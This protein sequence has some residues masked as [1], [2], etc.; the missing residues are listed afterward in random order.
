M[1]KVS[2]VGSLFLCLVSALGA[3]AQQASQ[4]FTVEQI[5]SSPFPS[6]LTSSP[7]GQ[8]LAWVFNH[9][10]IRNIWVAEGPD[11]KARRLTHY[12][13][14]NGRDIAIHGFTQDGALLVFS[15]DGKFNPSPEVR[16]GGGSKLFSIGW[17]GEEEKEIAS[18][19]SGVPAPT[20]DRVAYIEKGAVWIVSAKGGEKPEK[21]LELRGSLSQ[22]R[23]SPDGRQL[24]LRSSRGSFPH[25]YS[26]I[27]IL[28]LDS[29]SVSYV[30]PSVYLD[31]SP[32][33]SVDGKKLAFLRRLTGGHRS[34]LTATQFPVP[35]PWEIRV[36]DIAERTGHRLWRSPDDDNFSAA[37]LAWLSER[38]LIFTSEQDGWRRLYSLDLERKQP[39]QLTKGQFEV[40][41]FAVVPQIGKVIASC[42]KDDIDR[43]RLWI[44]SP[45][46]PMQALTTAESIAWSPT[47]AGDGTYVAYLASDARNPAHVRVLPQGGASLRLA[48]EALPSNFPVEQLVV[49]RQVI[50][51]A[52]DGTQIH[53]QLFMPPS[54]FSGR[55]PAV[56]YFH[57]GPVR[58]MLLGWHYSSYYHNAYAFNQYL[59]SRGYVVL[60]VNYRLGIGYGRKFRDVSDGGPRGA[61]EYQD[62]LAGARFLR[63][64]PEVDPARIGLWGGSYGGLMT[65]LGLARNSDLF[66]A[67][68]DLHGVHDWNQWQAWVERD[69]NDHDRTAWKAS[70][71]ADLDTWRSPVLLIHG[72]DDRNVSFSETVWLAHELE[73]RGVNHELLVFPD[74]VH[75]FLLHKNWVKAFEA[76]ADFLDRKLKNGDSI[77]P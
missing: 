47:P 57:G 73:K 10:G 68:V 46:Q 64:M 20:G 71:A 60:S 31:S 72:D 39:E 51:Q 52:T 37:E 12:D 27:A 74:D 35:D 3:G 41:S 69:E 36:Y 9:G 77:V 17:S 55:R 23:W 56:M 14:D 75:A 33:W 5:L 43:R 18:V 4:S 29:K 32:A 49:P 26:F 65:A 59:A 70:P 2:P 38:H 21:V 25:Q 53:G 7:S 15:R 1:K 42:N 13:R 11:F 44:V 62:L 66:A 48:P 63:S 8:R 24:A 19:G 34:V 76:A 61:S 54:H 67:G 16:G 30:D 6:S 58:Q 50:F 28:D 22:L 45:E 40:E